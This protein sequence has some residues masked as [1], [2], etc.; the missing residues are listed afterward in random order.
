MPSR[1]ESVRALC[2]VLGSSADGAASS[3]AC[4]GLAGVPWGPPKVLGLLQRAL[5]RRCMAE[6]CACPGLSVNFYP[7]AQGVW[8]QGGGRRAASPWAPGMGRWDGAGMRPDLPLTLQGLLAPQCP[9]HRGS[10][11]CG[12]LVLWVE[13]APGKGWTLELFCL[14]SC[15]PGGVSSGYALLQTPFCNECRWLC[16]ASLAVWGNTAAIAWSALPHVPLPRSLSQLVALASAV[17][18]S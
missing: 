16:P 7:F 10:S 3:L 11:S 5:Q 4:C 12:V 8:V 18:C 2:T 14:T 9:Q 1:A 17:P 15:L 13:G 6:H